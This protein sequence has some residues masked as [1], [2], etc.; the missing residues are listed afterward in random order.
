MNIIP[1]KIKFAIFDESKTLTKKQIEIMKSLLDVFD[2][3][4]DNVLKKILKQSISDLP[5]Y[6]FLSRMEPAIST[7]DE[8]TQLRHT[9][10]QPNTY[11]HSLHFNQCHSSCEKYFTIEELKTISNRIKTNLEEYLHFEILEVVI[12]LEVDDDD[13]DV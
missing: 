1:F 11:K 12:Y 7:I 10:I 4:Y 13:D 3:D 9:W 5:N 8:K 6:K 2:D